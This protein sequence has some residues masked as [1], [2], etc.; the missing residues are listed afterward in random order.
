MNVFFFRIEAYRCPTGKIIL[1]AM[2]EM[3]NSKTQK[4]KSGPKLVSRP[5]VKDLFAETVHLIMCSQTPLD[6]HPLNTDTSL[7]R[8]F[9]CVAGEK[10]EKALTF[11]LHS[12]RLIR[13]PRYNGYFLWPP[14]RMY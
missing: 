14:R 13:T 12:T 6:G 10:M 11:F 9:C 1:D 2:V 4:T 3:G 5:F 7:L 8:S